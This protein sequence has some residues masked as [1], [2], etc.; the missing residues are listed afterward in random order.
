MR[1]DL[2]QLEAVQK[3]KLGLCRSPNW[4]YMT[5]EG[6]QAF[7]AAV[8]R[9]AKA[10][11]VVVERE[12]P[13]EFNQLDALRVGILVYEIARSLAHEAAWHRDR[14][15]AALLGFIDMGS[16]MPYADY[17]KALEYAD[18]CRRRLA[19]H[20]RDLDAIVT[21]SAP[22][23]A[24]MGL[25]S[26]G[27]TAMNRLWTLLYG[28]CVT[29]PAGRGAAGMPVGVQFY[30]LPGADARTLAVAKWAERAL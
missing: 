3:P 18:A 16:A 23:E 14:I 6:I 11:A 24:P 27:E 1:P 10:G 21:P 2:R 8:Q 25:E 7:D 30:G 29:V 13:A 22:G 9:L 28:P 19:D 17:A 26:T 15:S 5:D 12:L 20:A 4:S